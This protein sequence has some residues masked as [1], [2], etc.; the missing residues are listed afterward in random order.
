MEEVGPHPRDRPQRHRTTQAGGK[1]PR[2]RPWDLLQPRKP[3]DGRRGH[4]RQGERR[5]RAPRPAR[6]NTT[7]PCNGRGDHAGR[8]PPRLHH[9][10]QRH[11]PRRIRRPHHRHH[12]RHRLHHQRHMGGGGGGTNS[13]QTSHPR[14]GRCRRPRDTRRGRCLDRGGH[15]SS[16]RHGQEEGRHSRWHSRRDAARGSRTGRGRRGVTTLRPAEATH[17]T[18]EAGQKA[19]RE[20]RWHWP[21]Q[22]RQA[23]ADRSEEWTDAATGRSEP[24]RS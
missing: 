9:H 6:P 8:S 5:R 1:T 19:S 13:R 23:Q 16:S 3:Y 14:Q 21:R 18:E 22:W 12:R 7:R 2:G 4:S 10:N 24:D 20:R 17:S 15:H 11:P